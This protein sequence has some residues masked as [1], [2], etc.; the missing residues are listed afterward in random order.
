MK[1]RN[2]LFPAVLLLLASGSASAQADV[3]GS[4][5]RFEFHS[6]FWINLHHFLYRLAQPAGPPLRTPLLPPSGILGVE[7]QQVWNEAISFYRDHVI[8]HD[9]L[10]DDEMR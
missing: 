2:A 3:F 9:L 1:I 8:Q 5:P 10:F 7:E 4:R 6:N